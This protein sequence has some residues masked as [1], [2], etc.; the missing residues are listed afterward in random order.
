MKFQ[1][2]S[3]ILSLTGLL[4]VLSAPI[5][6][7]SQSAVDALALEGTVLPFK[8]LLS[9]NILISFIYSSQPP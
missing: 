4:S 7:S 2:L 8:L 1:I 6:A 3:A 5:N 9:S